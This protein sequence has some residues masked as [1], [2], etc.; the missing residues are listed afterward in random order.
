M[1]K[2]TARG[3]QLSYR[4]DGV[5]PDAVLIHGAAGNMAVWYLCGLVHAL[6]SHFR[7]TA[8][9]LRGHGYSES[10]PTG[11]TSLDM[12]KD[13]Q[14]LRQQ[15]SLGPV[16]LLGHSFGAAI[17][18]QAALLEPDAVKGV[19]LSDA[20]LPGLSEIHG[21][22]QQWPGWTAYK[23]LAQELGLT[24]Q[25]DWDN[26]QDLFEQA[27]RLSEEQKKTWARVAGPGTLERLIRAAGTSCGRDVADPAGLTADRIMAV[28][29]PVVCLYGERSP[30]RKL[31]SYLSESLPNCRQVIIADAEHFGFEENPGEFVRL[32]AQQLCQLADVHDLEVPADP[33]TR[34]T[35]TLFTR[36]RSPSKENDG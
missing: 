29:Q 13:L 16:Y 8:Y 2:V 9:D 7:V 11:Y 25:D 18:L 10:T 12:A 26:L 1:P 30:F 19:I 33:S 31:C 21:Q 5:G 14:A 22:P 3:I 24:L 35:D 4:Q 28:K 34:R 36:G 27:T 17:A 32:A 20:Y 6:A 23:A 15:L